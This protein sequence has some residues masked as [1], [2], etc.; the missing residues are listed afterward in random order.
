LQ[1]GSVSIVSGNKGS[2]QLQNNGLIGYSLGN[3]P[4]TVGTGNATYFINTSGLSQLQTSGSIPLLAGGLLF[5]DPNTGGPVMA[6]AVVAD[7]PEIQ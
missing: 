2:F 3:A 6:A 1:S 7:P 5:Y 4:L